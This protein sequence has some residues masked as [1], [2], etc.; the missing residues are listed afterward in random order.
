MIRRSDS[1]WRGSRASGGHAWRRSA[2]AN[3]RCGRH[4]AFP[5][6]RRTDMPSD[7]ER[8]ML[9]IDGV[10]GYWVCGRS[11][12]VVGTPLACHAIDLPILGDLSARHARIC[13]Q[14]GQYV[15][16]PYR[17]VRLNGRTLGGPAGLG[18]AATLELGRSVR[19][20]F[21]RPHPLSAT[22]QIEFASG[23]RT[24]PSA[25]GVLLAAESIVL[26]PRGSSHVRCPNWKHE[27][28][29]FRGEDGWWCRS[30]CELEIGGQR[31]G[32]KGRIAC[33]GQVA[34]EGFSFGLEPL[35]GY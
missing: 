32:R 18:E 3:F 31:V 19:L 33:P 11:S 23:H 29:L 1:C 17:E 35:G 26:G 20:T 16:E 7:C 4:P 27:V 15:I 10:G 34:G 13:R 12:V 2:G 5:S 9:W 22:A 25:D 14:A 6:M 24:S 28:V 30:D 21:R 8:F